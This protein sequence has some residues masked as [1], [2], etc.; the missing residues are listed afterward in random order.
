MG[1]LPWG[2]SATFL[3][4]CD[5]WCCT[6]NLVCRDA[7]TQNTCVM[8]LQYGAPWQG[9]LTSDMLRCTQRC[10]KLLLQADCG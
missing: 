1:A 2:R 10:F 7:Y 5:P 4:L 3:R 8:G 9:V 6:V